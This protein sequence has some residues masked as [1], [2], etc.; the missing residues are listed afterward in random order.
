MY[1]DYKPADLYQ[2]LRTGRLAV[3][4]FV[5]ALPAN[6]WVSLEGFLRTVFAVN[7]DLLHSRSAPSVWWLESQRTHRQF[8]TTFDDWQESYGQFVQSVIK[9]P[10]AWLGSVS[11]AYREGRLQAFRLTRAGE[12]LLG[13]RDDMEDAPAADD[14]PGCEFGPDMV[15][16]VVPGTAPLQLHELLSTIGQVE[17]ASPSRFVY[18]LTADGVRRWVESEPQDASAPHGEW[19]DRDD[20]AQR[21]IGLL[22]RLCRVAGAQAGLPQTWRERICQ[23]VS[24]YG[25]LHIYEGLTLIELGDE[26]A[27]QELLAST[28]LRD[29][30][31]YEFSPRWIAIHPDA[32][33]TLVQEM[34]KRG[35]MPRVE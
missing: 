8:G 3:L 18:R 5:A 14:V 7:P 2:E 33:E 23:W 29:H 31:V 24:N 17:E 4:R 32:V 27:L 15:L 10:L 28:S 25:G 19:P 12:Y 35:Y 1:T 13:L 9:G 22:D 34:E 26:Y 30:V 21:M 20:V 6:R 16:S 11:L